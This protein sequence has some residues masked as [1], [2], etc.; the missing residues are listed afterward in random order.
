MMQIAA[1]GS[2]VSTDMSAGIVTYV[3]A[4]ITFFVL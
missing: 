2:I 4:R 1:H 3:L